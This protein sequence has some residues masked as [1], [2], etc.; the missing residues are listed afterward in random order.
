[1]DQIRLTFLGTS[2]G[3]PTRDRNVAC[4]AV[5]LDGH[6]LLFDCGEG[7]QQ[8]LLR[9]PLRLGAVEALFITHLHGDHLYGLP[10]LIA[11]L[12]LYSRVAP[13]DVYGPPGLRAYFEAVRRTS[14]FNPAFEVRLYE[15][16]EGD[17]CHGDG[18]RVIAARL[19]HAVECF[20][21]AVIEDDRRGTFDV[22]RAEALGIPPGPLFGRLQRGE[23]VEIGG[24]TIAPHEVMGA[25]RTGRRVVYCTDTRPCDAAVALA[26]NAD[27]LV[28]EATY[29]DELRAEAHER[30]HAT[31]REA[32]SVAKRADAKRLILTHFSARYRDTL[33]AVAE[34]REVFDATSAASDF[35]EFVITSDGRTHDAAVRCAQ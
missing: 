28:H 12:G 21:F 9:S 6:A 34:A 19:E 20:G 27:V 13:L 17:V 25:P 23:S 33:Q 1:M 5:V 32:A 10:G 4:V 11:T 30:F 8:Q 3:A 31:A 16:G 24:R 18:Y 14:Y 2:A 15:I 35:D 7:T 22:A 29:T 26:R